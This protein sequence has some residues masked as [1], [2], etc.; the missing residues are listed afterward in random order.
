M[1]NL[2]KCIACCVGSHEADEACL[3]NV[4]AATLPARTEIPQG[5]LVGPLNRSEGQPAVEELEHNPD[6][7]KKWQSVTGEP[8]LKLGTLALADLAKKCASVEMPNRVFD[9]LDVPH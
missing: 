1:A 5:G 3:S 6:D 4:A 8:M 9:G 7:A 2:V